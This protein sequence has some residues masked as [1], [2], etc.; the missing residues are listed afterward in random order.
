[1]QDLIKD[2]AQ[3]PYIHCICIIVKLGL[4]WGDV[5]LR[6]CYGLHDD[7]LSAESEVC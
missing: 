6:P 7:L 3:G 4:L 1:M 2:N 5:F